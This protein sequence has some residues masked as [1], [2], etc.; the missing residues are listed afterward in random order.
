ME[1]W[2]WPQVE[3]AEEE[4][5]EDEEDETEEEEKELEQEI[6]VSSN[7][8]LHINN[9]KRLSAAFTRAVKGLSN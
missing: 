5:E 1:D 6:D 7:Q 8:T 2:F 9:N 4:D 3:K